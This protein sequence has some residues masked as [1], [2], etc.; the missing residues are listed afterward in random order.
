MTT[1]KRPCGPL[2]AALEAGHG[3]AAL[4]PALLNLVAIRIEEALAD[5]RDSQLEGLKAQLAELFRDGLS[6][7]PTDLVEAL[8]SP[9]KVGA[10]DMIAYVLGN[11]SMAQNVTTR[12]W[13]RR[14][15]EAFAN[16]LTSASFAPYVAALLDGPATNV[17]IAERVGHAAETVSR[18][19]RKL[20]ALGAADFRRDGVHACNFLTPAAE[21]LA[22]RAIEAQAPLP[23]V[24]KHL[25]PELKSLSNCQSNF[26]RITPSFSCDP[27]A[28]EMPATELQ[29]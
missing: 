21:A 15:G 8:R 26:W 13:D 23:P 12:A 25:D 2:A 20:R 16:A 11:L 5:P 14:A 10:P 7:A 17:E 6:K 4:T 24:R 3:A 18:Q 19:L 29:N 1:E 9:D 28:S 27:A 22:R